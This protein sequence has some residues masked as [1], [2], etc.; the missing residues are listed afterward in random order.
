[1]R[2]LI[3]IFDDPKIERL[4]RLKDFRVRLRDTR[5][6]V[7]V[8]GILYFLTLLEHLPNAATMDA[9]IPLLL[10]RGSML[11]LAVFAAIVLP[12]SIRHPSTNLYLLLYLVGYGVS[13]S[14][15][16]YAAVSSW[17]HGAYPV[18]VL[19][20]LA[21]YFFVRF[22]FRVQVA[23]GVIVS[24]MYT[25]SVAITQNGPI[26]GYSSVALL[27]LLVNGIGIYYYSASEV[28]SRR[29][30]FLLV[31]ERALNKRL[32]EETATNQALLVEL[33]HRSATD[34]LTDLA[35]RRAFEEHLSRHLQQAQR[36]S[37]RLSLVLLDI[38]SFKAINDRNGHL[39]GDAVLKQVATVLRDASRGEDLAGRL[40]GD[41]LGII[42]PETD[43]AG[44]FS[45]AQRVLE[46][47]NRIEVT[48]AAEDKVRASIGVATLADDESIEKFW[49]RA[50]RALYC[51][52]GEGGNRV[53]NTDRCGVLSIS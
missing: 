5:I 39:A 47:I 45:T 10:I 49:D 23:G 46:S 43:N 35:N 38:D 14:Y 27:F 15:E 44:A 33:Q 51:A 48:P 32:R 53:V 30:F 41:E 8:S 18:V 36:H 16:L 22:D 11:S 42:L 7:L 26:I 21:F 31:Q 52:K 29:E 25:V 37:R 1:M 34:S 9:F 17:S 4:Y 24:A 12:R 50:D 3:R 40:G 2:P 13:E 6:V 28:R 20:I 19:M